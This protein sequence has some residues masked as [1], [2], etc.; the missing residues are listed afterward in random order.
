[1]S[2]GKDIFVLT[3]SDWIRMDTV[4][5][6]FS[7]ERNVVVLEKECF[8]PEGVLIERGEK[9][10]CFVFV[11]CLH[12]SFIKWAQTIDKRLFMYDVSTRYETVM[13]S[14]NDWI[15]GKLF[16]CCMVGKGYSGI[17]LE[18]FLSGA[19]EV[20]SPVMDIQSVEIAIGSRVNMISVIYET[21]CNV[22]GRRFCN[23][24]DGF[25]VDKERSDGRIPCGMLV[26]SCL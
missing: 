24:K 18:C 15:G 7:C 8:V 21:R 4:L 19:P 25:L 12:C 13:R 5:L 22:I 17:P 9:V 2:T 1:M 3:D 10:N 11:C 26:S 6:C 14:L 20:Y 23:V 16:V